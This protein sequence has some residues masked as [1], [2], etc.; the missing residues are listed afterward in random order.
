MP[1]I[2]NLQPLIDVLGLL[3]NGNAPSNHLFAISLSSL[4]FGKNNHIFY[5]FATFAI[6]FFCMRKLRILRIFVLFPQFY[7]GY[8]LN[9]LNFLISIFCLTILTILTILTNFP[10]FAN[11]VMSFFSSICHVWQIF[12]RRVRKSNVSCS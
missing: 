9:F 1:K 3:S 7:A 6:L 5:G 8:F 2:T 10:N 4:F 12:E 11:L